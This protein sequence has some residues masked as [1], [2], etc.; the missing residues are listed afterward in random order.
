MFGHENSHR[1]CVKSKGVGHDDINSTCFSTTASG[2]AVLHRSSANQIQAD[3]T[4]TRETDADWWRRTIGLT[5]QLI[6]SYVID[7]SEDGDV[8]LSV[9][10]NYAT[11]INDLKFQ[12]NKMTP[13]QTFWRWH[14]ELFNVYNINKPES[15]GTV[16]SQ[17]TN[18][19]YY[20]Y[21]IILTLGTLEGV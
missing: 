14:S 12:C 4:C 21:F 7:N 9:F 6:P 20:Y 11:C 18:F 15:S 13:R 5:Q 3:N 10:I 8:N 16:A 1:L 17:A 19:H 2:N